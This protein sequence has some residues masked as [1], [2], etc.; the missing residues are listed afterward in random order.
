MRDKLFFFLSLQGDRYR[1]DGSPVNVLQDSQAWQQAVVAANTGLNSTA[2]LLYSDFPKLNPG[3]PTGVT[4][5]SYTGGDYS[6]YLCLDNGTGGLTTL[7]HRKLVN[8]MG[9]TGPDITAM[10]A[11]GCT[12]IPGLTTGTIGRNVSIQESSVSTFGTQT[13][14]LGN[15]FN[16]NEASLRLDYNW[17]ASNRFYIN[18]NYLRETDKFGPSNIAATRG[19]TNPQRSNFPAGTLSFVHTF[20]PSILNEFR[21]GYL[22]NTIGTSVSVGGI[23]QIHY[24]NTSQ[25]GFG[26]YNGYPQN[27][28]ENV[29]TYSDMVSIGHGNHNMKASST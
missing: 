5:D 13:E 10:G 27:F 20:S 28:K 17:N 8:I 3:T 22:Q 21:A 18:Y 4:L 26:S 7:Q 14:S 19:F 23:P 9:V 16:G 12:N 2:S 15:L 11:A 29:Y 6:P 24:S 25:V 1:S